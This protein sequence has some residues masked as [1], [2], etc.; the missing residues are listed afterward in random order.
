MLGKLVDRAEHVAGADVL[1]PRGVAV[2]EVA[3]ETHAVH[4]V[5]AH[6]GREAAAQAVCAGDHCGA[7]ALLRCVDARQ[8]RRN[9]AMRRKQRERRRHDP[10]QQ[11]PRIEAVER[12]RRPSQENQQ[13]DDRQPAEHDVGELAGGC[14][15]FATRTA[16]K[17]Q[18]ENEQRKNQVVPVETP[19][20]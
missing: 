3:D 9:R 11:R 18:R 10:Q 17:G 4:R 2:L 1:D 7:L 19:L 15:A 14:R 13:A 20:E 6:L 5:G 8:Q 12:S 16:R